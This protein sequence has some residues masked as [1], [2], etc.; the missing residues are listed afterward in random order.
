MHHNVLCGS[1]SSKKKKIP[2]FDLPCKAL[3]LPQ[4]LLLTSELD[5]EV[6]GGTENN[7]T[8]PNGVVALAAITLVAEQANSTGPQIGSSAPHV[9]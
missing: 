5:P 7:L 2:I 8:N 3:Q 4:C 6:A 1:K 9:I